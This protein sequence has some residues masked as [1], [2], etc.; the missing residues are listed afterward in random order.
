MLV[1][2]GCFRICKRIPRNRN[3][4]QF[5]HPGL[6]NGFLIQHGTIRNVADYWNLVL[7]IIRSAKF[8]LVG[9][10]SR[11]IF[12]GQVIEESNDGSLG[13][14]D[15]AVTGCPLGQRQNRVK[16]S[17]TSHHL[18]HLLFIRIGSISTREAHNQ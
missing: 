13:G 1:S 18:P 7:P 4:Q 11:R 8:A 3:C 17:C 5:Y 14:G 2:Q 15:G 16:T 10:E 12:E 6:Y 9:W